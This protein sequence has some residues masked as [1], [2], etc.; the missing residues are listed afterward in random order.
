MSR[1]A[2]EYFYVERESDLLACSNACLGPIPRD[3]NAEGRVQ[4]SYTHAS[5][6]S[7]P[8]A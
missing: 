6:H 4:D 2:V 7:G 1:R 8:V 3:A 5:G